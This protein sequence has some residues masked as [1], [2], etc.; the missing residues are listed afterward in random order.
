VRL[1]PPANTE[2]IMQNFDA[3]HVLEQLPVG[4]SVFDSAQRL[5]TANAAYF[6]LL[7]LPRDRIVPGTPILD[8]LAYMEQRGEFRGTGQSALDHMSLIT[9]PG[10]HRFERARPNGRWLDIRGVSLGD[11][12]LRTYVD[13]TE[14]VERRWRYEAR[15]VDL[16]AQ[17]AALEAQL[18]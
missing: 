5:V 12:L 4:M 6:S 14:E 10:P 7:D 2:A 1:A 11:H 16:K 15:I 9:S 3:T 13:I 17:V 8:I 18:G